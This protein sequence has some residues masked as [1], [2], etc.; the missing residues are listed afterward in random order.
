MTQLED[1]M[2]DMNK[3]GLGPKTTPKFWKMM[4]EQ[5]DNLRSE[6]QCR[7]KWC[8]IDRR[9]YTT[10]TNHSIGVALWHQQHRRLP[11][12]DGE[13]SIQKHLYTGM[14]II[15]SACLFLIT[16]IG[17][18]AW[19]LTRRTTFNG[20]VSL[21]RVGTHGLQINSTRDGSPSKRRSIRQA[22]PIKV[23]IRRFSW[24]RAPPDITLDIVQKLTLMFRSPRTI[25]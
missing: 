18:Q 2:Q 12:F 15:K 14:R 5:M 3:R 1:I 19:I 9:T 8:V 11:G 22:R 16:H 23:S 4:S 17:L 20:Q 24:H 10:Y 13:M 7:D 6:Y 21:T 25:S